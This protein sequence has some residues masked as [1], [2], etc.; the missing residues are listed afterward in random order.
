MK[1]KKFLVNMENLNTQV[2]QQLLLIGLVQQITAHASYYVILMGSDDEEIYRSV[3]Q[4]KAIQGLSVELY[5]EEATITHIMQGA[6]DA[7]DILPLPGI[8]W[9]ENIVMDTPMGAIKGTQQ[10]KCVLWEW[11]DAP[12]PSYATM[13]YSIGD[14]AYIGPQSLWAYT[15]WLVQKYGS[16]RSLSLPLAI[17]LKAKYQLKY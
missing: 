8:G 16:H 12:V 2:Y 4:M 11:P 7:V 5:E 17:R 9:P 15:K 13:N 3:Q 1:A 6:F 14:E 10:D